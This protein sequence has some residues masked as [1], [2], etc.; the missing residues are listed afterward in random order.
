MSVEGIYNISIIALD[1]MPTMADRLR[2]VMH[3]IYTDLLF[4]SPCPAHYLL[5][6]IIIIIIIYHWGRRDRDRMVVGFTTT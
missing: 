3:T 2:N 6:I 4:Q 5:I 1:M